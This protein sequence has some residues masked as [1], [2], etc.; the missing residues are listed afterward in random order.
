VDLSVSDL[1]TDP[2]TLHA[3]QPLHLDPDKEASTTP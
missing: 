1:I 3:G 2:W